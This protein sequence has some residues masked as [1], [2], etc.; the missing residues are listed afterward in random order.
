MIIRNQHL[1]SGFGYLVEIGAHLQFDF[2]LVKVN[3]QI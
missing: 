1:F 3:Y 2:S